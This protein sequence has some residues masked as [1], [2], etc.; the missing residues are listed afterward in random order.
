MAN[1]GGCENMANTV[2][3]LA[4]AIALITDLSDRMI[5]RKLTIPV[6]LL[7]LI[8]SLLPFCPHMKGIL[9]NKDG[10]CLIMKVFYIWLKPV[11]VITIYALIMFCFG[12]LD[13]G[14]GQFLIAIAPWYGVER[15]IKLILYFYPFA[16][17][18]LLIYL[19]FEY[20]FCWKNLITNQIKN[21]IVYLKKVGYVSRSECACRLP[22]PAMVPIFCSIV[23]C[24]CFHVF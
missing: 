9:I 13:G 6:F 15:M 10:V 12:I 8:Y 20:N 2:V 23:F 11:I 3:F 5:Y 22:P 24:I 4:A 7:G 17:V 19:L 14:D 18:F 16:L 21:T 1:I